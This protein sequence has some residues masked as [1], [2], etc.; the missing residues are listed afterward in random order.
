VFTARYALSPYIKYI[1][2]VFK[3]LK[4]AAGFQIH[5][6]WVNVESHDLYSSP[7]IIQGD[8]IK[9]NEMGGA[10]GRRK[11]KLIFKKWDCEA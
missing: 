6:L 11:L 10:C 3:G 9:K 4:K 8:Q 2:F 1:R 7:N 5:I